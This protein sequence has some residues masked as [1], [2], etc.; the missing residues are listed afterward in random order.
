MNIDTNPW[1]NTKKV[2]QGRKE[3]VKLLKPKFRPWSEK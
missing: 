3:Q 1:S 2:L